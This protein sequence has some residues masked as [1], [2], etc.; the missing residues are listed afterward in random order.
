MATFL[1]TSRMSPALVARIEASVSGRRP[2]AERKSWAPLVTALARGAAVAFVVAVV[3]GV[4]V[5]RR[6]DRDALEASR[7]AVL[8]ALHAQTAGVTDADRGAAGRAETWLMRL[9]GAYEGDRVAD[10][11]RAPGA[12]DAILARPAMYARGPIA[13]FA[14][15]TRAAETAAAAP[16]DALLLCLM[17]PPSARVEK[18]LL[19]KVRTAYAAGA[20]VEQ[21][22]AN[23]RLLHE[24]EAGVPFLSPPWE[25]RVHAAREPAEIARLGKELDRAPLAAAKKALR[26]EV[27]I[28]ALDE[29]GDGHG[30]T[31][32][33]G[34]RPHDV[35]VAVVD[36]AA[37][38]VLVRAR[39]HVD[40][41]WI[42]TKVRSEYAAGIDACALAMDVRSA[43]AAR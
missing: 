11:A 12:L 16:K 4:I 9:G 42:T 3:A 22:T 32:L 35:R 43:V 33:D 17:D 15:A 5:M 2:G 26:A 21:R 14:S 39:L 18:T 30:P 23:V 40:P 31:E 10:E 13:G 41:S 28:A 27:L 8:D 19:T 24:A 34:E 37:D 38:K 29:P 6:R 25:E 20:G 7:T 36:L 1:T